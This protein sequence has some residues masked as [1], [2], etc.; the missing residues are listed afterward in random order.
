MVKGKLFCFVVKD[1]EKAAIRENADDRGMSMAAFIRSRTVSPD[2][3]NN[4]V[5]DTLIQHI[6]NSFME[7]D[8]KLAP[9][10]KISDLVPPPPPSA[11]P[12][13]RIRKPETPKVTIESLWMTPE[14]AKERI[15]AQKEILK[16]IKVCLAERKDISECPIEI[17]EE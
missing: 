9:T 7:L 10:C 1:K 13:E 14:E 15:E 6:D 4:E 3:T 11:I 2:M 16:E 17:L 5:T 12:I 8:S